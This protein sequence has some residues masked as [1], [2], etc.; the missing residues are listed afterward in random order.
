MTDEPKPDAPSLREW[1]EAAANL[2]RTTVPGRWQNWGGDW[3]AELADLIESA[4]RAQAEE[5]AKIEGYSEEFEQQFP[6]EEQLR[7]LKILIARSDAGWQCVVAAYEKENE[8]LTARLAAA[9]AVVNATAK[10]IF[11]DAAGTSKEA[12]DAY[13]EMVQAVAGTRQAALDAA[14]QE[15]TPGKVNE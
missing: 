7:R 3:E 11:L 15:T 9:E 8:R 4:L 12:D 14:K 5:V 1:A 10:F 2:W 13:A 6:I